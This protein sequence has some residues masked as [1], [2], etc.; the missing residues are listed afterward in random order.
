MRRTD[1]VEYMVGRTS[2]VLDVRARATIGR[3]PSEK[4]PRPGSGVERLAQVAVDACK[5]A[6]RWAAHGGQWAGLC[7]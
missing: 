6:G 5:R 4:W 1:A 3:W 2:P 7:G